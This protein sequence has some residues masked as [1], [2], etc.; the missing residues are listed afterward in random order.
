MARR[1]Q[2]WTAAVLA[3]ASLATAC[4]PLRL[5]RAPGRLSRVPV[6][7]VRAP[8]DWLGRLPLQVAA[9]D[10]ALACLRLSVSWSSRPSPVE[11]SSSPGSPV[12][13]YLLQ[14]PDTVLV[15]AVPDPTFRWRTLTQVPVA[16][17]GLSPAAAFMADAVLHEHGVTTVVTSMSLGEADR[18]LAGGHLPYVLMPLLAAVTFLHSHTGQVVAWVGAGTG[19]VAA[20]LLIG[21]GPHLPNL[22]AA[23]NQGLDYIQ[24]HR[25]AVVAELVRGDYPHTPLPALTT[26][27]ADLDAMGA[28]PATVY[29][30]Q[31]L[32]DTAAQLASGLSWPPY[33][34]SVDAGPARTAFSIVPGQ[35]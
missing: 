26:A 10:G 9:A 35:A 34:R 11:L 12:V 2:V 33:S 8:A 20:A 31:S 22:L 24:T 29:P 15:S 23:I 16:A 5:G 17:A 3:I 28:F 19:P 21:G 14:R 32:Y 7:R 4:G 6:I 25:P 13:G 18:G 27:I 1:L 30:S